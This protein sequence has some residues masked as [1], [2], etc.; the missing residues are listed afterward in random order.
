M[1]NTIL[2]IGAS[3]SGKSS[4][5]EKLNEKETF[6]VNVMGK[7]LPFKGGKSRYIQTKDDTCN[8]IASREHDTIQKGLDYISSK[9]PHIKTVIIDDFQYVLSMEFLKRS[10]EI[11]LNY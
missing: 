7:S 11:G 10:K 6:L 8:M 1:A 4:S 2:I 5:L 3:G 9:L